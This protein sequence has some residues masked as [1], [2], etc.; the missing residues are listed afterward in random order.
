MKRFFRNL[1]AAVALFAGCGLGVSAQPQ[2][3][4]VPL[5]SAVRYG[6]LDNGLTY[7]IRHN[8]TPKG[9]A[10]FFIAQ[11]V[12]SVLEEEN[13][14]GLA[15]FL[16]HM[17]FNGT[18]NFPGSSL[19]DWLETVGVKFGRNLNAYTS[20]DETVY[21]ISSV[22]VARQSVQDSCLLIL[23]DWADALLL[24]PEEIDKER[25]VI[26]EEWRRSNQGQMRILEQ[27]LPKIYPGSRYGERLPIGT[28]EVVDN[29]AP[30]ALRD[31]YETWYRPDNQGIIVVG[32]I[33][34]DY[35][36]GK[37][38][39]IF[40]D[41]KMPADAKERVYFDVPDTQGT[42]Y[43]VGSDKEMPNGVALLMF[44]Q[45]EQMLPRQYRGTQAYF[46]VH[47][48]TSM[49]GNMLDN[50]L[51]EIGQKP[52]APFAAASG[53]IGD[54]FLS[55]TKDAVELQ[56]VAKGND[57]IPGLEAAYTELQRAARHGFT[58]GEYERAKAD[59]MAAA[60]R[61]YEQRDGREN[62]SYAREYAAN[63]TNGEPAPGVATELEM[64][65]M[66]TQMV[67]LNAINRILPELVGSP[68]NR[69]LLVMTPD[70]GEFVI[71]TEDQLAAAMARVEAADIEAY[72][73]EMKTEPLIPNLP[74]PVKPSSVTEDKTLG[75][76]EINWPNG[77]N[78]LVKKTD[79][80]KGD[81][82][83]SAIAKGGLSVVDDSQ[84]ANLKF[85]GYAMST[86]GLGDYNDLDLQKYLQGKNATLHV[87]FDTYDCSMAGVTTPKDLP[88]FMELVYMTFTDYTITEDEF[89]ATQAKFEGQ[90]GNQEITP[91][92]QFFERLYK[93]LYESEAKQALTTADIKAADRQGTLD[94]IHEMLAHPSRYTMVFAGDIDME[95]F[96]PLANQYLGTLRAPKS[97]PVAYVT[98][99]NV[100]TRNGNAFNQET[101]KMETPQTWAAITLDAAIP[102][103]AKNKILSSVAGQILSNRLIKKI[104]EEMGATY[105]L[106]AQGDMA[107]NGLKNASMQ[108]AFPMKPEMRQEV[109]DE[110]NRMINGMTTDV[111]DDELAPIKEF[112]VKDAIESL[113]KNEKWAAAMSAIKALNGIDTFTT[114]Q[115]TVQG[116]TIQ[117][118]MDFM[119]QLIDAGNMRVF[120]LNPE[121]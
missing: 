55:S 57:V 33:D 101:F 36:E 5:D 113:E 32:D 31:Y 66:L 56:V 38:K 10:D 51:N 70:N 120:L 44:K 100:E 84:A 3:A 8:E 99:E 16:E 46:P 97:A 112:M 24:D 78:V 23:H 69:V 110:I 64:A 22:P 104:R 72:K 118:V 54:Y 15:H 9:Q 1:M 68:D 88:T 85:L 71:P 96:M 103:T 108:I 48:M 26:H 20:I 106:G 29:F 63:F 25:G 45:P 4:P 92:Y 82:R 59:Y 61:R 91:Q 21:N 39:D 19:I 102:Y 76:T 14:R 87:G 17:C 117:D 35:I 73:D 98:R 47:F 30:Q 49:I 6:K 74:A 119:K 115:E 18:T 52:D 41:I 93:S 81:I 65:R 40:S 12:G 111:T 90:L 13:Q 28:M 42:I 79:F 121:E 50:R 86:H 58:P 75:L 94:I 77:V 95:T 27:L 7:Y 34:V 62:T 37:I 2:L 116:L 53:S 67:P 114:A 109:L 105:S 43:A 89:A 83:F 60:E 11:K 107:R 80:K